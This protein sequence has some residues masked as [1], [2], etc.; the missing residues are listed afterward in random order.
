MAA[1]LGLNPANDGN[2]IRV[3]I[4][5]L[6]EE[7]RLEIVKLC[8][9]FGEDCKIA[10]RNIRRDANEQAKKAEKSKELSEDQEADVHDEVQKLTDESIKSI[11]ELLVKKEKDVME[12]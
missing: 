8:K 3:P 10:L 4:P 9:R 6:N 2:I 7:R 11:D 12:I 5:A 1:D